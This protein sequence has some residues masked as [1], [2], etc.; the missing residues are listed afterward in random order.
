MSIYLFDLS[1]K[2]IYYKGL[3]KSSQKIVFG[4]FNKS[5]FDFLLIDIGLSQRDIK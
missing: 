3:I 1:F 4:G 2:A 5:S